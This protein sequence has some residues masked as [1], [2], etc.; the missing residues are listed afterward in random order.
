[1]APAEWVPQANASAGVSPELP[2]APLTDKGPYLFNIATDP[3][4]RH[5]LADARP[6]K[7][8]ELRGR[9]AAYAA[10]AV[11]FQNGKTDLR[12]VQAARA[13]GDVWVPWMSDAEAT[14]IEQRRGAA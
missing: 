14:N 9:L 3:Q 7:L 11:P 10:T 2:A 1:M 5:N 4:E 8:A 6:D 13:A 12:A